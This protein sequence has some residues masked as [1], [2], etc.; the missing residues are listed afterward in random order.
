MEITFEDFKKKVCSYNKKNWPMVESAY[1]YAESHHK[2]Q[3]RASGEDYIIHPM[4]AVA[5]V[6]T[7]IVLLK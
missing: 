4:E 1:K 7:I 5:I 2:G 3:K 6:A